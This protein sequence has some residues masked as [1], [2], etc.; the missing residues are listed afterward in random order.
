MDLD[1][2]GSA[3]ILEE[4]LGLGA[5]GAVHVAELHLAVFLAEDVQ[6][7]EVP[8]ERQD[9]ALL[10]PFAPA[11][12]LLAHA[13]TPFRRLTQAMLQEPGDRLLE[14]LGAERLCHVFVGAAVLA[15]EDV[16]LLAPGGQ[17]DHGRHLGRGVRLDLAADLEAVHLRHHDVDD[18]E[19]GAVGRELPEG[20]FAVLRD[21]D[22]VAEALEVDLK[23]LA[24]V[25]RVVGDQDLAVHYASPPPE[26]TM[27]PLPAGPPAAAAGR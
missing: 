19:I 24:D 7:P 3:A 8:F 20:R 14:I 21:Q 5:Q 11:L 18:H 2:A 26:A 9:L 12:Q 15:P 25:R 13:A 6:G 4:L 16:L 27:R 22:L 10:S 1:R 23:E 17:E